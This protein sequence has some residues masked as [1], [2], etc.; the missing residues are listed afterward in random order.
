VFDLLARKTPE[1]PAARFLASLRRPTRLGQM[2]LI[3]GS[4]GGTRIDLQVRGD[5][6]ERPF[7][8]IPKANDF[9]S[10]R[11]RVTCFLPVRGLQR[12]CSR[13][14]VSRTVLD[15]IL[16]CSPCCV[17]RAIVSTLLPAAFIEAARWPNSS[18]LRSA[19]R[20]CERLTGCPT[21]GL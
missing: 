21:M 11:V 3:I 8:D 1:I 14:D 18:C 9:G 15:C 13:F 2:L 17:K 4:R 19:D 7:F 20:N 10:Q 12:R 5:A 16:R 6:L